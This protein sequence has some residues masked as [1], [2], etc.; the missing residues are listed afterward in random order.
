MLQ[1]SRFKIGELPGIHLNGT[2]AYTDVTTR[3]ARV[4]SY[5]FP[6]PT[7]CATISSLNKLFRRIA[8]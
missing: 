7:V 3:T 2:R 1:F 8:P 5:I 6:L 4:F